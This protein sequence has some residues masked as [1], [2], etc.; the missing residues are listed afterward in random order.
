MIE[1]TSGS[2]KVTGAALKSLINNTV[3]VPTVDNTLNV[4][5][6][7]A[8]SKTVGDILSGIQDDLDN[9][10][11]D[12]QIND[13]SIIDDG[14]ANIPIASSATY[15][16]VRTKL[17]G[18]TNIDSVDHTLII[19]KANSAWVK[20]GTNSYAPIVPSN[21]HEATFYG[22]AK[23]AGDNTQTVS[24]NEVG[25]YTEEAKSAIRQMLGIPNMTGE[26][27]AN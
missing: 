18:G 8:D 25:T 4:S 3:T 14:V 5:G 10:V 1:T 20:T 12:V 16:V 27:I 26:L 17:G 9:V 21:Q 6:A 24:S 23:A 7:A 19:N 15:G 2:R 22:L 13:I 11:T